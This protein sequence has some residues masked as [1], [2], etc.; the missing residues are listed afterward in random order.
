[1]RDKILNF[2]I[3]SLTPQIAPMVYIVM[4]VSVFIGFC[5]ATGFWIG[6]NESILYQNGVLV[7]KQ[8]WGFVLFMTATCAE[9]GMIFNKPRWIILG[10]I[11]GFMAWLFAS[12]ALALEHHWYLLGS[13]ALLHLLFHGYVYLATSLGILRREPVE[14][15][16]P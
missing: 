2:L 3:K 15:D 1:M 12:I 7:N 16:R 13:V 4:G 5:F 9:L 8:L 14:L 10:G 11:A 6:G